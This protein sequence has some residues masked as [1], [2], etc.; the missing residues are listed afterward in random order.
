MPEVWWSGDLLAE[1]DT[2][3]PVWSVLGSLPF[4]RTGTQVT[5]PVITQHTLVAPRTGQK[6]PANSRA[7]IVGASPYTAQWFDGA[8][9]VAMELIESSEPNALDLVFA[10]LLGQ[11]AIATEAYAVSVIDA[12]ATELNVTVNYTD[13]AELAG[14]VASANLAVKAATNRPASFLLIPTAEWAAFAAMS[15]ADGSPVFPSVGP[16][17]RLGTGQLNSLELGFGGLRA[18]PADVGEV[19]VSNSRAVVGGERGP[20]R[21][22]TTNVELM[23]VDVGIIGPALVVARIPAGVVSLAPSA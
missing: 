19:I 17:N 12:A 15:Y 7:L 23:G 1:V 11:Y 20:S 16:S 6:D 9:D 10:D 13:P 22:Q 3:R 4:P 8:V 18:V 14:F 2:Y 5:V 21:V